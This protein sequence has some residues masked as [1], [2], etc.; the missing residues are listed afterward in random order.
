MFM[1]HICL[2]DV[3]IISTINYNAWKTFMNR[4]DIVSVNKFLYHL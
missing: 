3:V 1:L 4:N 2:L